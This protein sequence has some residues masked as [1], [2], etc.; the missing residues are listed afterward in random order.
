IL[1]E[2]GSGKTTE[3]YNAALRLNKENKPA[4]FLR[5]EHISSDLEVAFEVGSYD[6]FLIWI[7]SDE[8][9]WLFLDSVDESRLRGARDFERAIRKL[10]H[11]IAQALGRAHIVIT[12]RQSAWRGKEDLDLVQKAFPS[13]GRQHT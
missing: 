5:L 11:H 3:I 10:S 13:G 8:E 4:F 12:S 1:S 9:G 6:T 2:A 7:A